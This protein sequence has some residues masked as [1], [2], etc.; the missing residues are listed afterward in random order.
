MENES[1]NT[2]QNLN[3]DESV[4]GSTKDKVK[5]PGY[6]SQ[7][8]FQAAVDARV[9]ERLADMKSKMDAMNEKLREK[10][11]EAARLAEMKKQA[12]IKALEDA[13]QHTQ[14]MERRLTESQEKLKA[15]EELI[16]R[17]TRDSQ[18][19]E[20]LRDVPFRNNTAAEFAYKVLV[21]ELVKD[22]DGQWVHRSG[23]PIKDYVDIFS[24]DADYSFL[25]KPK[26]TSGVGS[27][28][29]GAPQP[30]SKKNPLEMTSQE[31][32]AAAA[33]GRFGKPTL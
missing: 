27:E 16:T 30:S 9:A 14:A 33:A 25:I 5:D 24:K 29:G 8:E 15:A 23:V 31:L 10:E 6:S 1:E 26:P 12:E 32:L 13:G 21:D 7:E 20:A 4:A 18:L 22:G 17:L 3:T 2:P 28:S 11:R 19:K